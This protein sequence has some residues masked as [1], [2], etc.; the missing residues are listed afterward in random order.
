MKNKAKTHR[1]AAKRFKVTGSGKVRFRRADRNHGNIK[2]TAKQVRDRR[3]NGVLPACDTPAVRSLLM[4][5]P[6]RNQK[7]RG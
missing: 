5:P 3:I 1:G 6:L 7:Q 4:A 2:S